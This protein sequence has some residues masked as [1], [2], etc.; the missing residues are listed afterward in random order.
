MAVM[1]CFTPPAGLAGFA[2]IQGV[3]RWPNDHRR[4]G[5]AGPFLPAGRG[6]RLDAEHPFPWPSQHRGPDAAPAAHPRQ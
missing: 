1:W 5:C 4:Y 6:A 3:V 2:A